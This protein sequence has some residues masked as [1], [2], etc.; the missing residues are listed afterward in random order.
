MPQL[1]LLLLLLL[2]LFRLFCLLLLLLLPLLLLL[3]LPPPPL[4]PPLLLR[5]TLVPNTA[6]TDEE[7][8]PLPKAPAVL[9]RLPSPTLHYLCPKLKAP[10][11]SS[12]AH[13]VFAITLNIC[14]LQGAVSVS[15]GLLRVQTS[16]RA[17]QGGFKQAILVSE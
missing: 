9:P 17:L 12:S 10:T 4:P 15:L 2:L 14:M 6:Y 8:I 5:R 3:L 16:V 1:L 13:T 7:Q 11:F